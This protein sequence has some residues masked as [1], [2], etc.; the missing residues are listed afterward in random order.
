M[1][2]DGGDPGNGPPDAG[3]PSTTLTLPVTISDYFVP[4]GYMGDGELSPAAITVQTATCRQPRPPS[5]SGDCYLFTYH[6]GSRAWAGIYWQYPEK[7]W[8]ANPG[9]QIEAG[10]TKVT[11]YAAGTT[12]HEVL[13][14]IAGGENDMH[15]PCHDSFTAMTSVALTTTLTQYQINLAGRTYE[16]GVL[17]AFAWSLGVTPGSTSPVEFYLD[18]IRW[19]K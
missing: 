3:P 16:S 12:G 8:G 11:F 15:L 7:N 1:G 19:E 9:K 5:A 6:P 17:G 4:G 14:F 10:A 13:Q 18:T 2:P